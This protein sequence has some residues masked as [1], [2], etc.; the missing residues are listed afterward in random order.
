MKLSRILIT[1]GEPAGIG[2]DVLIQAAQRSWNADLIAITD[3][4]LINKRAREI[5]LPI[6][7]VECDLTQSDRQPHQPGK[8]RIHPV[9]F[10]DITVAG[11][12][13]IKNAY[14]VLDCLQIAANA[15]MEKTADAMV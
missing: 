3:P 1:P 14:A 15:C 4:A 6:Q 8:L 12:L 13:N 9:K 11:K 7:I 10:A 2:P 5:N